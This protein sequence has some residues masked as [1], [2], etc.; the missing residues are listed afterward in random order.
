M[1]RSLVLVAVVL[2]AGCGGDEE[3]VRTVTVTVTE[4]TGVTTPPPPPPTTTVTPGT[5]TGPADP[6]D[7][8]TIAVDEFNAYAESV[9]ET[10]ERDVALVTEEFVQRDMIEAANTTYQGN[11]NGDIG[12]T[13][14]VFDGLYDDS[15]RAWRYD[16]SL[17]RRDDGTWRVDSARWGQ[18]CQPGR[19]HQAFTAE[20]CI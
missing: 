3:T 16:L 6:S 8:G 11:A 4:T 10:W 1:R 20:P 17:S 18:K 2:A 9:E 19:G 15:V 13:S 14:I 7:E 12:T 5:W